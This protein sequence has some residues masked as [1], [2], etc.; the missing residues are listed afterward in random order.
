M[1]W[2]LSQDYNEAIQNPTQCFADNDLRQG[3]AVTNA[4]G[5]PQP[6]SG[7]FADVYAMVSGQHKWAVKCFTRPI[8][9][10]RER[11]AEISKYLQ[12][13]SLPFMV[14]FTFLDQGIMVCGQWYPILKMQW[15]EGYPLNQFVRDNLDKPAAGRPHEALSEREFQIFCKLAAG[16]LPTE[17]AEELHLSVKTVSTYRARVLEKMRLANNADLTYY[18][19]KNGL[20][21]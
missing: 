10:L 1:S 15:I 19:I 17:I 6:C 7:N 12:K 8:P 2:P 3:E 16:R 18:A 4:M 11:Y 9:G 21:E 14:E 13:L 5:L 20:I